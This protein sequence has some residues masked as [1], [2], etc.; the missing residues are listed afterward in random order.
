MLTTVAALL[1]FALSLVLYIYGKKISYKISSLLLVYRLDKNIDYVFK[2]LDDLDFNYGNL[3]MRDFPNFFNDLSLLKDKLKVGKYMI[4]KTYRIDAE[5]HLCVTK[6]V[7]EEIGVNIK[8]RKYDRNK[9]YKFVFLIVKNH[10]DNTYEFKSDMYDS[11]LNKN[12]KN[13][14]KFEIESYFLKSK[15]EF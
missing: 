13:S 8:G 12:L 11:L 6:C 7:N 4:L 9:T 5:R 2:F 10:K 15:G 3:G 14:F 1:I